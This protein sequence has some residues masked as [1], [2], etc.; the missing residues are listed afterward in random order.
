[1]KSAKKRAETIQITVGAL[2]IL[3]EMLLAITA[4][5]GER[6]RRAIGTV[7]QRFPAGERAAR[8]YF[9]PSIAS[10]STSKIKV[11]FGPILP[12]APRSP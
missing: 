10:N 8:D 12:P 9:S 6:Q 1:M 3:P 7:L 4:D 5:H 11:L 2:I